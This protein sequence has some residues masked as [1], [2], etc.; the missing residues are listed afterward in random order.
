MQVWKWYTGAIK[1]NWKKT[2]LKKSTDNTR[3]QG[4]VNQTGFQTAQDNSKRTSNIVMCAYR[5]ALGSNCVFYESGVE[6][7]ICFYKTVYS[8]SVSQTTWSFT[9]AFI[10]QLVA[11]GSVESTQADCLDL[12]PC[13]KSWFCLFCSFFT[14][15]PFRPKRKMSEK[16]LSWPCWGSRDQLIFSLCL[17]NFTLVK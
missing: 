10:E 16:G 8:E 4:D 1:S 11:G 7:T 12:L 3:S 6:L 9:P 13:T 2:E 14:C 17:S 5:Q 15:V